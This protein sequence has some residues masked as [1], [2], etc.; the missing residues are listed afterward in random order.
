MLISFR[1]FCWWLRSLS[2]KVHFQLQNELKLH[3]GRHGGALVSHD[4]ILAD[5]MGESSIISNIL[6]MDFDLW[7]EA[8]PSPQ[9]LVKLPG[10]T[11]KQFGPLG[12]MNM[13]KEVVFLAG[14]GRRDVHKMRWG[15]N[16]GTATDTLF[17]FRNKGSRL[18]RIHR[19]GMEEYSGE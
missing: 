12:A 1:Q 15:N 16:G 4:S 3:D 10:E 9:N 5:E 17:G 6:S 8:L 18:P 7:D 2:D 13:K 11:D 14:P 19:R